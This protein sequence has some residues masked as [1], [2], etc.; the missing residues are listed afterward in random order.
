MQVAGLGLDRD[1]LLYWPR[2]PQ[3]VVLDVSM[4]WPSPGTPPVPHGLQAA[5]ADI[6][7]MPPCSTISCLDLS[8]LP[9]DVAEVGANAVT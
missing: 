3:L 9:V 2:P 4:P 1:F 8:L 6:Q 5:A 7:A